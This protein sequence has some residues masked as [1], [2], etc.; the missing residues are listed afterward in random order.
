ME[1]RG[2]PEA[3]ERPAGFGPGKATYPA[4]ATIVATVTEAPEEEEPEVEPQAADN[5]NNSIVT[6]A[7]IL[8]GVELSKSGEGMGLGQ[9]SLNNSGLERIIGE[10]VIQQGDGEQPL[11]VVDPADIP[12]VDIE[13]SG[14][15]RIT[16]GSLRLPDHSPRRVR[17]AGGEAGAA[18]VSPPE[19][20]SGPGPENYR[21]WGSPS[22]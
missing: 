14:E 12:S 17:V 8:T 7:L 10:V 16:P 13:L 1:D 20:T 19:Q 22:R 15:G 2:L 4:L 3:A 21:P 9:Q 6:Q 5:N 11:A 18:T